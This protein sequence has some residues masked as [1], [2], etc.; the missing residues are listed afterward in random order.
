MSWTDNSTNETGFKVER[1][2]YPAGDYS[3]IA[4]LGAD[5]T[6]Y[7]DNSGLAASSTYF[8]R[9]Q[10]YITGT[11]GSYSDEASATT[12]AAAATGGG[13]GGGGCAIYSRKAAEEDPSPLGT[14][15]PLLSPLG[16]LA[17]RRKSRR[18]ERD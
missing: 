1:R 7:I 4:T 12:S 15:L 10:A 3:L 18:Q 17:W 16:Y 11:G 6:S 8:Y 9:V 13:G 5:N 2:L 14:I